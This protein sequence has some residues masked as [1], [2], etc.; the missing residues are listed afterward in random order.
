MPAI[1]PASLLVVMAFILSACQTDP[2]SKK[3]FPIRASEISGEWEGLS[4]DGVFYI[5]QLEPSGTGAIGYTRHD[6]GAAMLRIG[7]WRCDG[8]RV[9]VSA[10]QEGADPNAAIRIEGQAGWLKMDLN[11]LGRDWHRHLTLYR[12]SEW[13]RLR[14]T[15]RASLSQSHDSSRT[16]PGATK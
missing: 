16:A 1:K 13:E 12:A 2:G 10:G 11:V 7:S 9:F 4:D 14:T 6:E 8:K 15:V 3:S 5:V